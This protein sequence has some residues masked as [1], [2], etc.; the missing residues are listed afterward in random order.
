MSGQNGGLVN[1][2]SRVAY[3]GFLRRNSVRFK[4]HF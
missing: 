3:F 4:H 1:S 2:V